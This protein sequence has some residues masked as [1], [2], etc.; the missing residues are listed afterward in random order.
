MYIYRWYI[1]PLQYSCV[2]KHRD[3]ELFSNN[4]RMTN[5]IQFGSICGVC[6]FYNF[7]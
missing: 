4:E 1:K 3:Q 5:E 7:N 2:T 6:D